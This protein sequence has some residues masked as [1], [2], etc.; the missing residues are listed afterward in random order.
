MRRPAVMYQRILKPIFRRN[1][2]LF[3][4]L[5]QSS[6]A[7]FAPCGTLPPFRSTIIPVVPLQLFDTQ[8][9]SLP[10]SQEKLDRSNQ[11][12]NDAKAF[13]RHIK[14]IRSDLNFSDLDL[15]DPD[16]RDPD[17]LMSKKRKKI[18]IVLLDTGI[19]AEETR[20]EMAIDD[21]RIN[22]AESKSFVDSPWDQDDDM[23]GTNVAELA[24][25]AAPTAEI[26]IGKICERRDKLE[27]VLPRLAKAIRWA[28][29]EKE[30][31]VICLALGYRTPDEAVERAVDYAIAK[32]VLVVAPASN[33]DGL[34]ERGSMNPPRLDDEKNFLTLGVG[35]DVLWKGETKLKS[36]TSFA[37]PIAA[38]F[39]ACML[40]FITDKVTDLSAVQVK[41][42]KRKKGMEAILRKMSKKVYVGGKHYFIHPQNMCDWERADAVQR[43]VSRVKEALR[44]V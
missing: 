39:I 11:F 26:I 12:F 16:L 6:A 30:A 4:E 42:L 10:M 7:N 38:G 15:S 9:L 3:E 23:H 24:T 31:D 2:Q 22:R 5:K 29:K 32:R 44:D 37:A 25:R 34:G 36:G 17:L 20:M 28:V 19:D 8:D 43:A 18:R 33:D 21:G 35:I 1:G 40:E 27:D 14:A 41:K 13:F